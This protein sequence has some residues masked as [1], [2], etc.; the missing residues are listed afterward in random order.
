M[1]LAICSAICCSHNLHFDFA[2]STISPQSV[3]FQLPQ[4]GKN[5][6]DEYIVVARLGLALGIPAGGGTLPWLN[7]GTVCRLSVLFGWVFVV[8]ECSVR[9]R[10]R[11][12]FGVVVVCS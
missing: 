8:L 2:L 10:V 5:S 1:H 7:L 4:H 3:L 12:L 9:V 6:N 11:V